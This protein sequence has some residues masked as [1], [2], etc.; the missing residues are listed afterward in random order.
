MFYHCVFAFDLDDLDVCVLACV[1][2][3]ETE[4]EES[5]RESQRGREKGRRE[6]EEEWGGGQRWEKGE[7]GRKER[8]EDIKNISIIKI[9]S[10]VIF[11]PN[12]NVYRMFLFSSETLLGESKK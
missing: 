9:F 7:G 4:L 10:G 6:Q 3:G 8:E 2:E 12:K 5:E 11:V 1:F